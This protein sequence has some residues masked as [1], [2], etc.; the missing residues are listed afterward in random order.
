MG[1]GHQLFVQLQGDTV[2]MLS[3]DMSLLSIGRTPDNGL[4]LP[5]SSIAIR[6][7]EVRQ[8]EGRWVITDL[9]NG[10]TFLAGHRLVPHQP[11]VL[12]EGVVVQMGPYVLAYLPAPEAPT[13]PAEVDALPAAP[14]FT[15][16]PLAPPRPG[17][18]APLAEGSASVYL[19]YLPAMFSESE[20]LARYLL[21][22]QSIWEP[23]QHRQDHLDMYFSP[24]TA[25]ERLLGWFAAWLGLE[26]DPHWPEARK[27]QWL[28][29][30]MHL[31]RWRGTRYGLMRALEIGCGVTPQITE[32]A[33]GP[34]SVTV[35]LPEPDEATSGTTR[36]DVERLVARHLP[37]HVRYELRYV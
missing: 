11:Q 23:L 20:F 6:H 35:T 18:P 2:K 31:L 25:P 17:L 4:A 30:A 24:A 27:R 12:E 29:E 15:L 22:F 13:P 14:D 9:G 5:H 10:E 1:V 32:N 8:L 3:L 33:G 26:V 19:D 28:R 16:S 21:I 7:A 34:Y 36:G 37:A